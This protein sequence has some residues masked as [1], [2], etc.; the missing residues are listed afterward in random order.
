MKE[1]F[2]DWAPTPE[3]MARLG[4]IAK[5]LAQYA[6]MGIKLTLRQLF[7]Q[8]VTK[9]IIANTQREYKKLG[10]LLSRAR[11]AGLIDWNIIEDR[12]R[13]PVKPLEFGTIQD[14][15]DLAVENFRLKRW[16]DQPQYVEL[17]VEK[18][19][20]SSVIEPICDD[21]HVT[22]MVNRGYSSSSA[23]YESAKRIERERGDREATVIYLGDFDPSG[24]DMV[25]DIQD[26]LTLFEADVFVS[27]LALNMD[28][29][30]SYKLP[31]NP[32]KRDVSGA[33][34]DSRGKGFAAEHGLSSY[35]VDALPP[36]V[37][38]TMIRNTIEDRMDLGL[39][40]EIIAE[41]DDLKKKLVALGG[42]IK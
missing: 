39:Y 37:L 42:K 19:A 16:R 32:L 27:K 24:E 25:R 26:R 18:D 5:V 34:T 11:L 10:D 40:E 7:Y 3:R 14:R 30:T 28:Q 17:W 29:V 36:E 15:I 9:N 2:E 8:L 31:P 33:L 23:M 1:K 22:M 35:E 21:L 6:K 4:Q 12:V 41:E 13:R 20:L 38:Q